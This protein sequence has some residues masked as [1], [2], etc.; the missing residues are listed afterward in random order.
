MSSLQSSR[1]CLQAL[2]IT[3]GRGPRLPFAQRVQL[4]EQLQHQ[5]QATVAPA[6]A[7]GRS[8]HATRQSPAAFKPPGED[9]GTHLDPRGKS[10]AQAA[11]TPGPASASVPSAASLSQRQATAA[12]DRTRSKLPTAKAKAQASKAL[13]QQLIN[14]KPGGPQRPGAA[15]SGALTGAAAQDHLTAASAAAAADRSHSHGSSS[16]A[17]APASATGKSLSAPASAAASRLVH[18]DFKEVVA[19]A[20]ADSY[21][22]EA[23]VRSGALPPGAQLLEDDEAI[24]IPQWPM[25]HHH[26][27]PSAASSSGGGNAPSAIEVTEAPPGTG[28]VFIFRSGSYVTW[29]LSEEQSQRFLRSVIRRRRSG[30]SARAGTASAPAGSAGS[31]AGHVVE[32]E[33]YE[34]VGDEAMEWIYREAEPTR[35]VGDVIVLGRAPQR[36]QQS[37]QSQQQQSQSRLQSEAQAKNQTQAQSQSQSQSQL[38]SQSA[39]TSGESS[40]P[41]TAA[42]QDTGDEAAA[43]VSAEDWSPLLARLAFSQGLARSARLS[44]QE[45]ALDTFLFSLNSIPEQLERAGKVPLPRREVIRRMGTILRLR[46]RANLGK[47]NFLDDPEGIGTMGRWNV[48]RLILNL[49]GPSSVSGLTHDSPPTPTSR[50]LRRDLPFAGHRAALP[51]AER[52]ARLRREPARRDPRAAHRALLAPHGAH[53]HLPHRLRGHPRRHQPRLRPH[54]QAHLPPA[55]RQDVAERACRHRGRVRRHRRSC[56]TAASSWADARDRLDDRHAAQGTYA[57]RPSGR[58]KLEA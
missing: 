13:R 32:M 7:S 27:T 20:T 3:I 56:F 58:R 39:G 54:A 41:S 8:M 5:L 11:G 6:S 18:Q 16:K 47:D 55:H 45:T 29:G 46:Q 4:A 23:L 42:E 37:Q 28:E 35:V 12:V 53:H 26:L 14:A 50:P 49:R 1:H 9:D 22:L 34:H 48:S 43:A 44:A 33:P 2:R 36:G 31:A 21:D 24:H 25:H 15:D 38:R 52:E 40:A 17:A 10:G 51:R 30:G 57:A 19:W